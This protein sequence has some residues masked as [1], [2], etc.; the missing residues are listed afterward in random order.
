MALVITGLPRSSPVILKDNKRR[1]NVS[2]NEWKRNVKHTSLNY[3]VFAKRW[4]SYRR[5]RVIFNS[6]N[7]ER[8]ARLRIISRKL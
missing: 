3:R 1:T 4:T 5:R 6:L 2:D 8:S 7:E